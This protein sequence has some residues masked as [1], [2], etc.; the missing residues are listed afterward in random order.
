MTATA[1]GAPPAQV[2]GH[3]PKCLAGPPLLP[4]GPQGQLTLPCQHQ[5]LWLEH[6]GHS[7][8]FT[9]LSVFQT[10]FASPVQ[11]A[12]LSKEALVPTCHLEPL[13]EGPSLQDGPACSW[14]EEGGLLTVRSWKGPLEGLEGG[15]PSLSPHQTIPS[16]AFSDH[17]SESV[18]SWGRALQ[19]QP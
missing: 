8:R 12:F 19:H 13:M 16:P 11:G 5:P 7:A 14:W 3:I 10:W 17:A 15:R 18:L 4:E 1:H 2:L 6:R 9:G